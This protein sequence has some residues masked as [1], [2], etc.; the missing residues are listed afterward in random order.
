MKLS[1][2]SKEELSRWIAEKNESPMNFV[3][4]CRDS[5]YGWWKRR[6]FDGA[7]IVESRSYDEPEIAM[8]MLNKSSKRF[9]LTALQIQARI[10]Y[11]GNRE[12]SVSLERAVA[13]AFA[14]AHGW[15]E[16]ASQ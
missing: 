5:E 6:Y 3:N 16:K 8:R 1:Q 14:L 15:T 10:D 4:T 9:V 2:V 11:Y 12:E 7:W 13:E